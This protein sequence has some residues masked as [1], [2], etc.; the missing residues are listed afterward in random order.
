M[1]VSVVCF[2][3]MRERLPADAQGNTAQLELEEE[4]T[5]RDLVATL[6]AG[7]D[8]I[9]ALLVDGQQA[10]LAETLHEGAAVTLMPPFTGGTI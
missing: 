3:R 6:G 1:N 10:D 9:F 8:E 5:V 2:G 4:A 7:E